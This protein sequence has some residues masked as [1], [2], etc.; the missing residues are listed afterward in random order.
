MTPSRTT[1]LLR[2]SL[3]L[4]LLAPLSAACS[5]APSDAQTPTPTA[6]TTASAAP[7]A[8]PASTS[9]AAPTSTAAQTAPPLAP[10]NLVTVAELPGPAKVFPVDGAVLLAREEAS[11]AK[12]SGKFGYHLGVVEGD[13]VN[14]DSAWVLEGLHN[15]VEMRGTWPGTVHVLAVGDT[16][17]TGIAEHFLLD[18][19]GIH[20]T[21]AR[22]G[23]WYVGVAQVGPSLLALEAPSMPFSPPKVVAISGAAQVYKPAPADPTKCEYQ[24]SAVFPS[25]FTGT[26][27]GTL[28]SYGLDCS[29]SAAVE[30]WAA[31]GKPSTVT[32]LAS[33]GDA[34]AAAIVPGVNGE[35]W[36]LGKK[37]LHFDGAAWKEQ[38][39]PEAETFNEGAVAPDGTLWAIA[40]SG[41]VYTLRAGAW[42]AERLPPAA[43][44]NHLAIAKDGT[45]WI[46]TAN[47]LLRSRR[48][49]DGEGVK[50]AAKAGPPLKKKKAFSPGGPR[51]TSNVVVLYAFTKVTPDD[52]DF[53]LTRKAIKGHKELSKVQF[54]VTKDAGQKYFSAVSPDFSTANKVR[55][56]IEKG[57]KDAKPAIVCA[58]PEIVRE[59][60]IDL[61]TGDVQK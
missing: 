42:S 31:A 36:L 55:E 19:K 38:A 60:K 49:N 40:S 53:P 32:S 34:D 6:T 15:V 44:A 20:P 1:P 26:T 10:P 22:A 27:K 33:F 28:L 57:V 18:G 46:T 9:T 48:P 52:Y 7:T 39:R 23:S 5:G 8:D 14:F 47:A 21:S 25:L 59:L 16:G 54:V 61:T 43:T 12:P 17:R 51:C 30:S 50:V 56:I 2:A 29:G 58:E 11:E 13:A 45:V 3:A 4:S 37:L 35:A 24:K 41:G